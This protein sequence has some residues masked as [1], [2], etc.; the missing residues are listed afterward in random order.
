MMRKMAEDRRT[1]LKPGK[2]SG[3][4]IDCRSG[5]VPTGTTP[6]HELGPHWGVQ[7]LLGLTNSERC[8]HSLLSFFS[9]RFRYTVK[10]VLVLALQLLACGWVGE[11]VVS[12]REGWVLERLVGLDEV[13]TP[14]GFV[15]WQ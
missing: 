12:N 15:R 3:R 4:K 9:C 13:P 1:E 14:V 7:S 10:L 11:G 6:P 8:S 5:G 2:K